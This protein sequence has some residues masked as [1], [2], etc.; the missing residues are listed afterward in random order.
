MAGGFKSPLSCLK[1]IHLG[2]CSRR[3]FDPKGMVDQWPK[4]ETTTPFDMLAPCNN[5]S[6]TSHRREYAMIPLCPHTAPPQFLTTAMAL[7]SLNMVE[8]KRGQD[9]T[10]PNPYTAAYPAPYRSQILGTIVILALG[11]TMASANIS[12]ILLLGTGSFIFI[13]LAEL[14]PEALGVSEA[15]TKRGGKAGIWSLARK[16]ASSLLGDASDRHSA[17]RRPAL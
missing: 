14:S 5:R 9:L 2:S 17:H 6:A 1:Q 10:T 8:R 13:A 4:G 11:G 3:F 7:P 12:L 15:T 16:L